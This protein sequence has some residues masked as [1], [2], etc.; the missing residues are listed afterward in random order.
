M[1][2]HDAPPMW[3]EA[4]CVRYGLGDVFTVVIMKGEKKRE[5]R[6]YHTKLHHSRAS[7]KKFMLRIE[8]FIICDYYADLWSTMFGL[9]SV[10]HP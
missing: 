1:D 3:W 9:G 6:S 5:K 7:Y 4:D 8:S 10:T 2:P